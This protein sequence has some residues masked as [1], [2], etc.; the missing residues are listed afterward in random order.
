MYATILIEKAG[1][2]FNLHFVSS[3][4]VD[5]QYSRFY[6]IFDGKEESKFTLCYTI[7]IMRLKFWGCVRKIDQWVVVNTSFI[8]AWPEWWEY[9]LSNDKTQVRI[10][11]IYE[12][13]VFLILSAWG[14]DSNVRH[15]GKEPRVDQTTL[16]EIGST[17]LFD[18]PSMNS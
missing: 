4:Y 6:F 12:E 7:Y 11:S 17:E 14:G 18:W 5:N 13:L 8:R 1:I 10:S 9:S 3:L 2:Q 15:I 16:C